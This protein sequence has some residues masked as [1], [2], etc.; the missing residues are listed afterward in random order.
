ME[1]YRTVSL[2]LSFKHS[3][4]LTEGQETA[5]HCHTW[6]GIVNNCCLLTT[7]D[8]LRCMILESFLLFLIL[9]DV[10]GEDMSRHIMHKNSIINSDKCQE[11]KQAGANTQMRSSDQKMATETI[12]NIKVSFE[13]MPRILEVKSEMLN[14]LLAFNKDTISTKSR[15]LETV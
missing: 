6:W 8:R 13:D 3:V 10:L 2:K 9:S 15:Q 12:K 14:D 11:K 7:L 4:T 5:R 1:I